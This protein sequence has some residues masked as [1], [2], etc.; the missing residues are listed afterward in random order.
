MKLNV[1]REIG[2]LYEIN[3]NIAKAYLT[4]GRKDSIQLSTDGINRVGIIG[5]HVIIPSGLS[6]IVGRISRFTT[7]DPSFSMKKSS[8]LPIFPYFFHVFDIDLLGTI[9]SKNEE[10]I[11]EKGIKSYPSADDAVYSITKDELKLMFLGETGRD[12]IE[13]GALVEDEDEKANI[14]VEYLFQNHFAV[15]GSTGS[16]KTCTLIHKIQKI[17]DDEKYKSC[18]FL[19]LDPHGEY[20]KAFDCSKYASHVLHLSIRGP[21]PEFNV[22]E[23]TKIDLPHYFFNF[24]E[25]KVFFRPAPQVQEPSLRDAI[26]KSRKDANNE[27]EQEAEYEILA[28]QPYPFRIN[29][30]Y[31]RLYNRNRREDDPGSGFLGSL[32]HRIHVLSQMP[33]LAF[34]FHPEN[35]PTDYNIF[36]NLLLGYD[37]DNNFHKVTVLDLSNIPRIGKLLVIVTNFL[38]RCVF[39]YMRSEEVQ[40]GTRHCLI[41]LE[42]AHNY[43]PRQINI[44]DRSAE[45]DYTLNTYEIIAK[46]GR[47]YGVCLAMS[48]QRPRD[49]SET[50]LSQ[51]GTYFIHRLSNLNDKNILQSAAAEVDESLLQKMPILSKQTCL[52]MGDAIKTSA[53]VKVATLKFTPDSASAK[54]HKL[55]REDPPPPSDSFV[56][57]R[58]ISEDDLASENEDAD[59][60]E[61]DEVPF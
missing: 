58:S 51:C 34:I 42:E 44:Y 31:G 3:G 40:R 22:L 57:I 30:L 47:K 28:D 55:W 24:S 7:E 45:Y 36:R 46:E 5:Q 33:E 37:A 1:N 11:Y 54:I 41:V 4:F 48:S 20:G 23:T 52:I 13:I 2:R 8:H 18:H 26:G 59:V 25:Y 29:D 12:S 14:D 9:Y 6:K 15:L 35:G 19:V 10:L 53:E 32:A 56:Q 50:V 17:I 43:V 61:D 38:G 21:E 39:D 27:L 16:G 60:S 49:L